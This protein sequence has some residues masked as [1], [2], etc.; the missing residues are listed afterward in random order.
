MGSWAC[1]LVD[2]RGGRRGEG[3][4]EELCG[5]ESGGRWGVAERGVAERG[6]G[7][8]EWGGRE[9]GGKEEG[10]DAAPV[11]QSERKPE[12]YRTLSKTSD[13]KFDP[14]ELGYKTLKLCLEH[15]KNIQQAVLLLTAYPFCLRFAPRCFDYGS[16]FFL[17]P[18]MNLRC[19][20]S[21]NVFWCI[22]FLLACV[23]CTV[24]GGGP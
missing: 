22:C 17:T 10:G 21:R 16:P 15:N 2:R 3:G 20:W 8:V 23:L 14:F 7:V 1:G 18:A 11:S 5:L 19:M 24:L 12:K 9:W 4:G 6:G 13:D